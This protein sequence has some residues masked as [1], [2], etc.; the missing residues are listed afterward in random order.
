MKSTH[1]WLAR[2]GVVLFLLMAFVPSTSV[3]PGGRGFGLFVAAALC[4]MYIWKGQRIFQK[5]ADPSWADLLPKV[6]VP[7]LVILLTPVFAFLR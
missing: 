5:S 6:A 4:L 7:G 3:S 1:V 2:V